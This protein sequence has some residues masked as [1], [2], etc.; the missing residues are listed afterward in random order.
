MTKR[1]HAAAGLRDLERALKA[2]ADP[3][4]TRILKLLESGELCVCQL[5]AVLRL[6]PS[7]VSKHL[8]IL[9]A[10][11]LVED[12]R[13][14]RWIHYALSAAPEPHPRAVLSLLGGALTRDPRIAADRERLRAVRSIPVEE[15]C[16]IGP[17]RHPAATG[18][19][20][21]TTGGGS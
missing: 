2:A 21:A 1:G 16:D 20:P 7:T 12:R 14:G 5:Q 19:R 9:R 11:G 10:A 8:S 18:G 3:T 6:A 13:A 17:L 4:R 15:L